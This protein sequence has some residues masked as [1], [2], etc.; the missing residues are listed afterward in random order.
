MFGR[1]VAVAMVLFV[2][3]C[4][5]SPTAQSGGGG[6]E[7]E[8]T[9][10]PVL[11]EVEGLTGAE[12][13]EALL[14]MTEDD[15]DIT[16]YTSLN[17]A[18]ARE[19]L[20]AYQ[21]DTG[22][23]VELYRAG[24][25]DVRNR[26]L[27]EARAGVAGADVVETNGPEMVALAR[28]DVFAPFSSPVQDAL[29]DGSA[30]ETWTASRLNIFTAAWNTDLVPQGEQPSSYR[31]LADPTWDG[32]IAMQLEDYEWYWAV[33]MYLA[34]EEGMSADEVEAYFR[35]LAS[36]AAFV[37]SHTTM[38][39]LLT[40]G[41]YA[42]VTSDYSYG[43]AEAKANGAPVEWR[44]PQPVEPLFARPNGVALVRNAPNPASAVVF[45]EWLLSDGQDV[46]AENNI[47]P[48]REDLLDIGDLDVRTIDIEEYLDKMSVLMKEYEQLVQAG[49]RVED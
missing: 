21:E 19:V 20:A 46:L 48:T 47:D 11:S 15:G 13:R 22:L 43:V 32:R 18:V 39:Q 42:V 26:L 8:N 1:M 36:G 3:A 14:A 4:G 10:A 44:E 25:E 27:E 31:D 23:N 28:E 24:S 17:E 5:T 29:V 38:R 37:S 45:A 16:W 12:R 9:I 49:E 40:A 41:E 30:R 2:A 7:L 33:K 34:D 35:E 6:A